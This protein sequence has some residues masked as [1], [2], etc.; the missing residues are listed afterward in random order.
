MIPTSES[1]VDS[2]V[3]KAIVPVNSSNRNECDLIEPSN[4]NIVDTQSPLSFI[5]LI[6]IGFLKLVKL[7]FT[8]V[9]T[10]LL[11]LIHCED[12]HGQLFLY[13]YGELICYHW[14]KYLILFFFLPALGLFPLS[15]GLSLDLLKKRLIS[16]NIFLL[17]CTT[18]LTAL[19]LHLRWKHNHLHTK[20]FSMEE[21]ACI[22]EILALE[23]ALFKD[24]DKS[25][26]WPVVQLYRNLLV[27]ILQTF[28][29]NA[30][31]RSLWFFL[32]FLVF[33]VHD[34]Y[35]QPYKHPFLNF[36]QPLTSGCLLLV[37][38]CSVPSSF[39]SVGNVMALPNMGTCMMVL[40][41]LEL[42]LFL[43]VPFSLP[44][45][46]VGSRI[47]TRAQKNKKQV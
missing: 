38:V 32:I 16:T 27:V 46:E 3:T 33:L 40:P 19:W 12:I 6:K 29:L 43:I 23:E 22:K 20:E 26:R 36:L 35:R 18:P 45:W 28:I 1:V 44:L 31:F 21:E 25:M 39:S 2:Q 9:M 41:F 5:S 7:I 15:F 13:L 47:Q 4:I 10:V 11:R 8:A 14:W 42:F 17:A 24:D 37:N 30:V 34:W